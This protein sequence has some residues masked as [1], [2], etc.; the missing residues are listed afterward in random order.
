MEWKEKG[1]ASQDKDGQESLKE[2]DSLSLSL[3]ASAAS[4]ASA[5]DSVDTGSIMID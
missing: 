5:I 3:S 1:K 2:R 4:A